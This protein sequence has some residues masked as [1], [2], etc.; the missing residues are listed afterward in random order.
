MKK[1]HTI[2]TFAT[3]LLIPAIG[4][5]QGAQKTLVKSFNLE[6][7]LAVAL[8]VVGEVEVQE[9]SQPYMRVQMTV[10]V[11]NTH[12]ATLKSLIMAGR[13]NIVGE[14]GK[15]NFRISV[16]GLARQVSIGGEQL[17]ETISFKIFLP[18]N[19]QVLAEEDTA[20]KTAE[21]KTF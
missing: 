8:D 18:S 4:F 6:G 14:D 20:M 5:G 3:L 1:L 9:W 13:Y 16:P 21:V 19:V 12:E 2:F 17:D 11:R 10:D 15:S 7:N